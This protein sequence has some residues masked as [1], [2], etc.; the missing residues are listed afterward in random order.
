MD[1]RIYN[2]FEGK[3]KNDYFR[4]LIRV[5]K[6][7]QLHPEY[8]GFDSWYATLDNLKLIRTL[9]WQ[10]ITR[11]KENRIVNPDGKKNGNVNISIVEI[12]KSGRIVHL[13]GYGYVKV[14]K[15]GSNERD[16]EYWATSDLKMTTEKWKEL[17]GRSWKIKQYHRGIKQC[18]GVDES[19]LR[20]AEGQQNH[21]LLSIL[22]FLKLEWQSIK[23]GISWYETKTAIT[24][25]AV[26]LFR[27]KPLTF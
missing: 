3:T 14:F 6:D 24:R 23:I 15:L 27:A 21:I 16:I 13:K 4:E 2:D 26:R 10:W 19:Q 9:D 5:A 12:P 8:V 11:F 22:A 18:C 20:T 7:R 1:F 25:N 17:K